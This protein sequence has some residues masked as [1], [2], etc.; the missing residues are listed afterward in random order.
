MSSTSVCHGLLTPP[1]RGVSKPWQ[2]IG[3]L[4]ALPLLEPSAAASMHCPAHS[5]ATCS[6]QC[7]GPASS[8]ESASHGSPKACFPHPLRPL[9]PPTPPL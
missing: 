7:P 9:K 3:L 4:S 1:I 8:A 2:F 6:A 5:P